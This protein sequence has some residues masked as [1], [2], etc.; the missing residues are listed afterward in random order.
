MASRSLLKS[1]R[2]GQS[3][4]FR[5]LYIKI[6]SYLRHVTDFYNYVALY[7]GDHI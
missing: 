3:V 1:F 4:C 2:I 7:K 6:K 5:V